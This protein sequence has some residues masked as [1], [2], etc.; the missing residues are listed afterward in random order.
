MWINFRELEGYALRATDGDLGKVRDLFFDD[1]RWRVRY[2]LADTGAWLSGHKVLLS[3]PAVGEPDGQERSLPVDLTT[4]QVQNAP[5]L[6]RD[7]PQR[8]A[9]FQWDPSWFGPV[10]VQ[11]RVPVPVGTRQT[12]RGPDG[13]GGNEPL[14]SVREVL[15]DRVRAA[16]AD[17]AEDEE[18]EVGH[19]DDLLAETGTWTIRYLVVDTRNWLPGRHVLVAPPW[20]RRVDWAGKRLVVQMTADEIRHSPAFDPGRPLSR[21]YEEGL[22]AYYG[23]P[24]YWGRE[25]QASET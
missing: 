22:Y 18:V 10:A 8:V 25:S 24:G 14:R 19:V 16:A 15:G 3:P 17:D 9:W 5:S 4:D 23:R 1:H 20:I 11:E 2:L 12:E 6:R 7:E 13:P 21:T